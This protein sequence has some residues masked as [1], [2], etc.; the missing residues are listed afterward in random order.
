MSPAKQ[1]DNKEES[2]VA[3]SIVIEGISPE[4]KPVSQSLV[5]LDEEPLTTR[6]S[7]NSE[8]TIANDDTKKSPQKIN[9]N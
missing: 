8:I 4:R 1:E 7:I 2:K 6:S 9:N 5:V 3:Q